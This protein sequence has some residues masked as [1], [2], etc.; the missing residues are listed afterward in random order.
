MSQIQF[1]QRKALL[2]YLVIGFQKRRARLFTSMVACTRW[3]KALFMRGFFY[4]PLL[5]YPLPQTS[6]PQLLQEELTAPTST[7]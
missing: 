5:G 4:L 7:A 3:A 1:R 2:R 6:S